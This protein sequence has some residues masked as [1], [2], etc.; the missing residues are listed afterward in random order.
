MVN[1]KIEF[2]GDKQ[3]EEATARMQNSGLLTDEQTLMRKQEDDLAKDVLIEREKFG[4]IGIL[5]I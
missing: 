3:Q 5:S 2:P 4:L 1:K